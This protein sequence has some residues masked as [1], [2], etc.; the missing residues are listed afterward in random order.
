MQCHVGA[1]IW[2]KSDLIDSAMCF[3]VEYNL[4]ACNNLT[5]NCC[6]DLLHSGEYR[7]AIGIFGAKIS[8]EFKCLIFDVLSNFLTL[9]FLPLKMMSFDSSAHALSYHVTLI[10]KFNL[11]YT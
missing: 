6:P 9:C 3:S 8:C 11:S 2:S 7:K 1:N 5:V 4:Q 10:N